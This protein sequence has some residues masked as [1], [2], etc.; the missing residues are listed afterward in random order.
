MSCGWSHE[1]PCITVSIGEVEA[2][3]SGS[4]PGYGLV[5]LDGWE[6]GAP[7]EGG[8][9]PLESADGGVRG[10]VLYRPRS[11]IIEGDVVARDHLELSE[12]TA[13]LSSLGRYEML[14]VDETAHAGLV[15][16]VEV[17]RLRPVQ[18]TTHGPTYATWTMHVMSVDW[19]RFGV[20]LQ[21][22]SVSAAGVG[23]ENIGSAPAPTVLRLVGPLT[24]PG[25]QWS[26]RTWRYYG[27]I[28][29]GTTIVVDME[30]RNVKNASTGVQS[31]RR[32]QGDWLAL[33]PGTTHVSRVGSGAGSVTVEWR[34]AWA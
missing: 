34:S 1:E 20:D 19:R 3:S 21:S 31:R 7:A 13:G 8:P 32:A 9:V 10:E 2:V 29:A 23:L 18:I 27:S 28:P 22:R 26:G 33:P 25:I 4:G 15:R 12:L 11:L 5:S 17:S 14:T 24:D 30:A 6:G 16:E